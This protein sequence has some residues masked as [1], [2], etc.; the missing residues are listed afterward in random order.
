LAGTT[1]PSI[2][3]QISSTFESSKP[4]TAAIALGFASQASC[5][6]VAL[7]ETKR[8]PSSKDRTPLATRAENSP[9]LC[10]ATIS[11]PIALMAFTAATE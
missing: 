6:A 10:P 1:I 11:A 8:S 2:W 7:S 3:A 4:K 5:I 9:K